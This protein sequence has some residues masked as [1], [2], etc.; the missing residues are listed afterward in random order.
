MNDKAETLRK[1]LS[2]NIKRHR[3]NLGLTQEKLAEKAGLSANM[4]NDIEGCR[5]WIS[6]NTLV[7]LSTALQIE[8]YRLFMPL[9]MTDNEIAK[10]ATT[11]LAKDLQKIRKDFNTSF[12]NAIKARGLKIT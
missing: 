11:D 5:S 12:E 10:T 7:K 8:T 4:V 3:E 9:T 6:D 1:N 2:A